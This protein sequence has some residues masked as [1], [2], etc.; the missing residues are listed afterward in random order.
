MPL[1]VSK[2]IDSLCSGTGSG[3]ATVN[4]VSNALLSVTAYKDYAVHNSACDSVVVTDDVIHWGR[5]LGLSLENL[6]H[7]SHCDCV[8]KATRE[9]IYKLTALSGDKI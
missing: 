1:K 4:T 9:E 2:L 5:S 8:A 7:H 3:D 6:P